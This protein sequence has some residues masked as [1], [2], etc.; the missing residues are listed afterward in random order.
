MTCRHRTGNKRPKMT[1]YQPLLTRA[2]EG[3]GKSTGESRR[4]LYERARK[5]LVTQ[6]RSVEPAL[7][8]SEITRERLSLEEAIRKAESVAARKS[9]MDARPLRDTLAALADQLSGRLRDTYE[10]QPRR[11]PRDDDLPPASY[12]PELNLD[13]LGAHGDDLRNPQSLEQSFELDDE[14]Q[15]RREREEQLQRVR[16]EEQLRLEHEEQLRRE[17]EEEQLR[18]EREEQLR[19]EREQELQRKREDEQLRR[20]REEEKHRPHKIRAR[21]AEMASPSP[22]L[23]ADGRLDAGPNQPYDVPTTGSDLPT[24]PLRQ[25]AI[26]KTILESLPG[27]APRQLKKSLENYDDE[28]KVRGVQPI[29]GLLKDMAAIIDADVGA[30]AA[31]RE[32]LEEGIEEAFKRFAENHALFVK[33]FPLDPEREELYERTSVD[34]SEASGPALSAPFEDVANATITAN[35]AGLTTDDFVKIVDK[36][37]EFAKVISTLPAPLPDSTSPSGKH[38]TKSENDM[39][40]FPTVRPEDRTPLAAVS[41]KKR[42]VLSGFGFF[43]RA[44]NLMGSTATL[45]GTEQGKALLASLEKSLAALSKLIN[46]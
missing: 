26:I 20:E 31:L 17:R 12:Q 40:D 11:L 8:E 27:N 34:E 41:A 35:K 10:P 2:I 21:L 3:L 7:S 38:G 18:L 46:F 25:Q 42:A 4:V 44:Y 1:D 45:I 16:E 39:S 37:A 33:H 29:L 14:E 22:S 13:D 9:R 36:L 43:E 30:P 32:W 5:A 23:T 28:L 19:H 24:L 6:L 15:L